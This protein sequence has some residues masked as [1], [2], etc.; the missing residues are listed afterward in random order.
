MSVLDELRALD[1]QEPGRWP[2]PFRAAAIGIVLV[3]VAALGIW[4]FV[5]KSEVPDLDQARRDEEGLRQSFET[6]QR[7]AA[8]FDDYL[9]Q[10]ATIDRDFSTMLSQLPG[11]TEVDNLLEDISQ[12]ALAAGLD[13]RL[14]EPSAE[15]NKEFYAELP[16][17]LRYLGSY[18]EL[19]RFVSDVA[20]LSRIVT[21]HDI[22]ITPNSIEGEEQLQFDVTAKTYR[23]LGDEDS[24]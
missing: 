20:G 15:I 6:K 4:Q 22:K 13:V 5:V 11:E 18:H 16:F 21:L 9:D 23:Y 24:E 3:I 19:A 10:L 1:M 8:N 2:L 12:T 17:K 14:F 7:K